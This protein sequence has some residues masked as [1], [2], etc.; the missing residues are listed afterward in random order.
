MK[1]SGVILNSFLALSILLITSACATQSIGPI[2]EQEVLATVQSGIPLPTQLANS[3]VQVE[4]SQACLVKD[5]YTIQT[6]NPQ[7]DLVAWSPITDK[8]AFVEPYDQHWGMFIGRLMIYDLKLDK[9]VLAS[10]DQAVTGDLTWS[11]DGSYLSYV[12]LEQ[13]KKNYTVK[14]FGLSDNSIL[15]A[16]GGANAART[17]DWSSQKGIRNWSSP[18]TL[19]VTSSCG[20]DCSRSYSYNIESQQLLPLE[21]VRKKDD[22]SLLIT[23]EYSSPNKDWLITLDNNNNVWLSSVADKKVSLILAT[24]PMEEIKWSS[25]STYFALRTNEHVFIYETICS[26]K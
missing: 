5:F 15:D 14:L 18:S 1:S 11:P 17:D 20:V 7:G 6:Q 26:Q 22:T 13:D 21:E 10:Q 16:F 19:V 8:L 3:D 2:S 23:N 9:S 4:I 25:D 24:T 12:V